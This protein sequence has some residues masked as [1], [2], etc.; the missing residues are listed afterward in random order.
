MI[1]FL[2]YKDDL[3]WGYSSTYKEVTEKSLFMCVGCSEH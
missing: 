3:Q 2:K 1:F